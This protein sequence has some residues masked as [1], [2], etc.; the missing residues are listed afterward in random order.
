MRSAMITRAADAAFMSS[1]VPNCGTTIAAAMPMIRT[2]TRI[3]IRVKA[4]PIG[5]PDCGRVAWWL[6]IVPLH[7]TRSSSTSERERR[8]G[9]GRRGGRS[10]RGGPL[11]LLLIGRRDADLNGPALQR[12]GELVELAV[13]AL[14]LVHHH[15]PL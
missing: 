3:S 8:G 9:R 13:D 2:T 6:R 12:V 15:L 5:L 4:D 1:R 14:Q 11:L 10:P 7:N